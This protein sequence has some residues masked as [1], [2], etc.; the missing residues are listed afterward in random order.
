MTLLIGAS[1]PSEFLLDIFGVQT[2][3]ELDDSETLPAYLPIEGA[4]PELLTALMETIAYE[5]TDGGTLP[6][7]VITT[8]SARAKPVLAENLIEDTAN[9]QVEF[10]Y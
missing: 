6:T 7:R 10:T 4:R 8:Q 5:R 9:Q 3:A 2:T 1:C